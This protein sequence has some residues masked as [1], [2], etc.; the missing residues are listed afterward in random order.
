RLE[1]QATAR[2]DQP[3]RQVP[4]YT[5]DVEVRAGVAPVWSPAATLRRQPD[6]APPLFSRRE[7]L[8]FRMMKAVQIMAPGETAL[9]DVPR[10]VP[11]PGEV[12]VRIEGV[13]TCPHWDLHALS[14]ED[15]FPGVPFAYP[16][17]PGQPGHEL[18]GRVEEVAGGVTTL[19]QGTRVAAW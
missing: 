4:S 12:L 18:V 13:T 16:Q 17:P 6:H 8:G 2:R 19:Q 1:P 9:V 7:P 5:A 11:G 10:P 3:H 15:M 14:G